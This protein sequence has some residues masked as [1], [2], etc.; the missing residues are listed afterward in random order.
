MTQ[1]NDFCGSCTTR[2][3]R[4]VMHKLIQTTRQHKRVIEHW[5][6]RIDLN[7]SGHRMLMY[8]S[9]V[10]NIPSQKD[11]AKHFKISPA[12]VATTLKKL[13]CDGYIERGKRTDLHDSRYNGISITE[14]GRKAA[15]DTEKYFRHVD[16]TALEGFSNDEIEI[17]IGILEKIQNNLEKIEDFCEIGDSSDERNQK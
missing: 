14:M 6:S 16:S 2:D 11:L 17:F 7:C 4:E 5:S 3:A 12:A 13:E 9:R 10:D 8:L 15:S 1:K